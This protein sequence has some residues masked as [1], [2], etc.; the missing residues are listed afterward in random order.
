MKVAT[1]VLNCLSALIC[2]YLTFTTLMSYAVNRLELAQYAYVDRHD[3]IT[4]IICGVSALLVL[5]LGI[6][7]F[8]CFRK[9]RQ[10][11]YIAFQTAILLV[12]LF[13]Y[14]AFVWYVAKD[15]LYSS[16]LVT[17][18]VYGDG[19]PPHL[20]AGL[21]IWILAFVFA[22]LSCRKKNRI[23]EAMRSRER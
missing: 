5:T 8:A 1:L 6:V 12:N 10:G 20:Y 23:P 7:C 11:A 3:G 18:F 19:L 14:V 16:M 9:R 2:G 15:E 17:I 21:G 22:L 4:V 13:S